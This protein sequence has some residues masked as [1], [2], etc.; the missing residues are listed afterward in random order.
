MGIQR[1]DFLVRQFEE[2]GRVIAALLGFREKGESER[3]L[4]YAT[5]SLK[6]MLDNDPDYY[7]SFSD[8]DFR[9]NLQELWKP[10]IAGMEILS[11]MLYQLGWIY[12]DLG[13]PDVASNCFRKVKI[14]WEVLEEDQG[15]FNMERNMKLE[16]LDKYISS[17]A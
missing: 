8:D 1:K 15:T 2:L 10:G 17:H 16:V 14:T 5:D 7:L 12:D 13:K 4:D 9:K 3:A 11:E 6:G